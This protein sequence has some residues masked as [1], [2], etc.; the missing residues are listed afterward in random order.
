[1]TDEQWGRRLTLFTRFS[2]KP[3]PVEAAWP[4]ERS[5]G[6]AA[7]DSPIDPYQEVAGRWAQILREAD[8]Y[9]DNL[10]READEYAEKVH[11]ETDQEAARRL[12]EV[13]QDSE[14]IRRNATEQ[15]ESMTKEATL[16]A[17]RIT[18][19]AAEELERVKVEL[20]D[21]RASHRAE[22]AD[23]AD[24]WQLQ[25]TQFITQLYALRD[26]VDEISKRLNEQVAALVGKA[27]GSPADSE[28]ADSEGSGQDLEPEL[29]TRS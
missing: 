14:R 11:L 26:G 7:P 25:R 16:E 6:V 21:V 18:R 9:A 19:G 2:V 3:A 12:A 24:R 22:L 13:E 28:Q 20:A 27:G 15:A 1:L 4:A 23:D 29:P 5:F 8:A 10:R 17:E